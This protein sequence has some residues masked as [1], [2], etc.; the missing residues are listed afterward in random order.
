MTLRAFLL[1]LLAL[2]PL[3]AGAEQVNER[4]ILVEPQWLVNHLDDQNLVIIDA[5]P[6]SA[7]QVGHIKGA[8]SLSADSTAR[9]ETGQL[10][11][12]HVLQEIFRR[13]GVSADSLVIVYDDGSF[14]DAARLFWL[15][16]VLGHAGKVA[17]LNAGYQ[18][19]IAAE[20]PITAS[21]HAPA[22]TDF[23]V[24][25]DPDRIGTKLA[26]RMALESPNKSIVDARSKA[27]YAGYA[28]DPY[29]RSGHIPGA[30]N[31]PGGHN[32]V[33][34]QGS[35]RLKDLSELGQIYSEIPTENQIYVYC[36]NG[37]DS[38][39][40]YLALRLVG[41]QAAVY[42]GGWLEWRNDPALPI[43]QSVQS[44]TNRQGVE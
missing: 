20:Y 30:I 39:L 11:A 16:E 24:T 18:E 2:F 3:Y 1:C 35:S 41:R 5:R 6:K 25:V 32:R 38:A 29:G 26:M 31:I 37:K 8:V 42:G 17:V 36:D 23:L 27:E 43:Q 40:S 22:M 13:S 10:L 4:P 12:L 33:K 15:F 7:Y 21:A 28:G 44:G 14:H 19:W 9:D 34:L